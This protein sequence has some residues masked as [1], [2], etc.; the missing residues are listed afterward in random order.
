MT[1]VNGPSCEALEPIVPVMFPAESIDSPVGKPVAEN[2]SGLPLP[3]AAAIPAGACR[4]W[5]QQRDEVGQL[6][7]DQQIVQTV[8]DQIDSLANMYI[9]QILLSF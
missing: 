8:W 5:T 2:E 3:G 9:W 7:G 4:P 6:S 1:T